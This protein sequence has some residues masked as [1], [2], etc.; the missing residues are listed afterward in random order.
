MVRVVGHLD[1]DYFYAQVEE[2]L[3]PG[4]KGKPVV[5]CVFSGRTED[6]GVVATANYLARSF[7]VG[8][9]M[10]IVQAK[11]RLEKAGAEIVRMERA[12]YEEVS[13][14]V[15]SIVDEEVDVFEQTGIDEAF[16][17]LTASSEGDYGRAQE[18]AARVKRV[19]LESERLT[20]SIGI[21]RSKV[22]AKIAS[23]FRKPD[24][25]TVVRPTETEAFLSPLSVTKLYGVGPKS[26]GLLS[27]LGIG[28]VGELAS[29]S[30]QDLEG[31][32]G[33]KLAVYLLAAAR[34]TDDE[35]V[36]PRGE[37]TQLSRI[38]TLRQDTA[39]AEAAFEQLADA[40]A[41]VHRRLTSRSASFRTISVIGILS[42]LTVKTK[43]KTFEAPLSDLGVMRG[44]TQELLE[45]LGRSAGK[46]F[47]R[48]GIRV[49]DLAGTGD[50][51]SLSE[52]L[53]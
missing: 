2:V 5:V 52:F 41:D 27:A 17:D 25:L 46:E 6:S 20:C 45:E 12:K 3:N 18:I 28:T 13:E 15:M 9:G 36:S 34:G 19:V 33:R 43:S 32:F 24:G 29:A 23:D 42:D 38:V 39:D 47:R 40:V 7:G 49:S 4:L 51:S 26:A 48:A 21:G 50:Q 8:S 31:K 11:R 35:P 1:L 14:R 22:V 10:P 37:P 30:A 44:A 53:R 16:L